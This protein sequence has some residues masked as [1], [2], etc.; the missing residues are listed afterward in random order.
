MK[1]D[2]TEP[3]LANY[4]VG[5]LHA[6]ARCIS[7]KNVYDQSDKSSQWEGQQFRVDSAGKTVKDSKGN[8][9]PNCKVDMNGKTISQADSLEEALNFGIQWGLFQIKKY[10]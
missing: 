1:M 5:Y 4:L 10:R 8:S 9:I 2:Y 6:A 3:N 7:A